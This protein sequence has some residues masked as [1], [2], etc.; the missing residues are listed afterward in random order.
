MFS[1]SPV[2]SWDWH[3]IG[4]DVL[5]L[6]RKGFLIKLLLKLFGMN[7]IGFSRQSSKIHFSKDIILKLLLSFQIVIFKNAKELFSSTSTV[8]FW[9]HILLWKNISS[10]STEFIIE[11][12][13][14]LKSH[15]NITRS[16]TQRTLHKGTIN[17]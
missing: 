8:N 12:N 5:Y 7:E 6:L 15:E 9:Y 16:V 13:I 10:N 11:P 1:G 3:C 4:I 14:S 17:L 2:L